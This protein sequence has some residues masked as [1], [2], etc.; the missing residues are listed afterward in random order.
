MAEPA[1]ILVA[2]ATYNE[3]ESQGYG[4]IEEVLWHLHRLGARFTEVPIVF[5]DRRAGHSKINT[6][7]AW[8]AFWVILRLTKQRITSSGPLISQRNNGCAAIADC[9]AAREPDL[10]T[11]IVSATYVFQDK[12]MNCSVTGKVE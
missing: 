4:Y 3:I 7:E 9:A 11:S 5:T 8:A 10:G 12:H 6:S 2:V 1:S